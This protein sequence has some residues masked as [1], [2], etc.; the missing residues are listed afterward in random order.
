[1]QGVE[2]RKNQF[3]LMDEFWT[4]VPQNF[5]FIHGWTLIEPRTSD[6]NLPTSYEWIYHNDNVKC[7]NIRVTRELKISKDLNRILHVARKIVP[8][9]IIP[10]SLKG[11]QTVNFKSI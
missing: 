11:S 5:K 2:S 9:H 6:T 4:I 7:S 8:A 10:L 1:M 3:S